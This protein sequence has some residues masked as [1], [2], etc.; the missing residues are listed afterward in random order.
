MHF[1]LGALRVN[2]I[3]ASNFLFVC[4]V[5]YSIP[6]VV[7]TKQEC[8]LKWEND[9]DKPYIDFFS[10]YQDVYGRLILICSYMS[11]HVLLNL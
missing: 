1:F 10:L 5:L 7:C 4:V 11:A 9:Y 6:L 3:C 2:L 8:H